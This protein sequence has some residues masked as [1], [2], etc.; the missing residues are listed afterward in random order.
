MVVVAPILTLNFVLF[1]ALTIS[2]L[3]PNGG[4]PGKGAW[5]S[6]RAE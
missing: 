3:A 2:F 4:L 1:E 6:H 5:E